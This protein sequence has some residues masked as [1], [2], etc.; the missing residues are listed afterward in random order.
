VADRLRLADGAPNQSSRASFAGWRARSSPCPALSARPRR[1]RRRQHRDSLPRPPP[2]PPLIC[3]QSS[4][5]ELC[6][7]AGSMLLLLGCTVATGPQGRACRRSQGAPQSQTLDSDIPTVHH[8]PHICAP[9][10]PPFP[11]PDCL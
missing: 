9:P 4:D 7:Y 6:K 1:A 2:S 8:L 10:R 11:L 5:A 3:A